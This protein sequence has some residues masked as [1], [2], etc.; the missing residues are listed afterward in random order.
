M[1][2]LLLPKIYDV[3][4]E[5]VLKGTVLF[6]PRAGENGYLRSYEKGIKDLTLTV[7]K[8]LDL[9]PEDISIELKLTPSLSERMSGQ[10][11]VAVVVNSPTEVYLIE[12]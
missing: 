8:F 10:T 1:N 9:P 11:E 5:R 12:R 3:F 7:A 6:I 2:S 4:V